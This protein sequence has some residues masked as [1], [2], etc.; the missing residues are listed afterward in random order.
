MNLWGVY[1]R[2]RSFKAKPYFQGEWEN[3]V[4]NQ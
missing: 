4:D 1:S 3:V 2:G